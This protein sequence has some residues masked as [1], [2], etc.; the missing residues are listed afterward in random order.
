LCANVNGRLQRNW[1]VKRQRGVAA[2]P[3]GS[4]GFSLDVGTSESNPCIITLEQDS[5]GLL[6]AHLP[7]GLSLSSLHVSLHSTSPPFKFG[8]EAERVPA[9]M[10]EGKPESTGLPE[11]SK[12]GERGVGPGVDRGATSTQAMLR[13]IQ[14]ANFEAQVCNL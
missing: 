2:G 8:K 10:K 6:T 4:A 1:K 9:T 3:V 13:Q 7:A 5:V 12:P 11:V 14:T